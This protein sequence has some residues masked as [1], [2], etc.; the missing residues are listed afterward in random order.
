MLESAFTQLLE[1]NVMKKLFAI[2]SVL[3]LLPVAA[4]AADAPYP[5]RTKFKHVAVM[6]AEQLRRELGAVTVVDV[7]SRY[8]YETLHIQG[9][10]HIPLHK[11]KLPAEAKVLRA[12]SERP[13]V[14]YCNGHS[15]KKSYEAAEL[16]QNAGVSK[17]YAYDAGLDTWTKLY[18]ELSVL[19]G[20][21]PVQATELIGHQAF[22][23]R[24]L[25]AGEFEA[26]VEKGAVVLDIRDLR[27]RDIALFPFKELRATLDDA[28]KI[29]LAV[30]EAKRQKKP[31]LVYDKVGKQTRWFQYYLEQ[32]GVKDYYF[33]DGGAEGYHEAKFGKPKFQL[34]D[35]S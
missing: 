13:I 33:L 31:L 23:K 14:F 19:L 34:P 2:L 5:H 18:P 3:L 22:Q 10:L 17:V 7:R 28:D 29:A 26:R 24:V 1:G 12:K 8:E 6:E 16:A 21:G 25:P 30:G 4:R 32:Q 15:C 20:R 35:Q 9:A 11:E 27:Q